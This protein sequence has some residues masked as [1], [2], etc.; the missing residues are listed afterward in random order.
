MEKRQ[1]KR[2]I[3]SLI[4][5][6]ILLLIIYGIYLKFRSVPTCFDNVKNQNEEGVDCGGV[7]Q[8][9]CAPAAQKLVVAQMGVVPSG[10]PGKY[11]F[12]V[13]I[14]NPNATFGDKN[15]YYTLNFKNVAGAVIASR[16]GSSYILPG[17][18]KYVIESNIESA[19]PPVSFDFAINSSDWVEFN[20]YYEKPDLQ[21][22]N[23]NYYEVSGGVGFSEAYGLLKNKSAYDFDL[24]RVEMILKDKDGKILAL[25]STQMKTVAADEQR[26]FKVAWPNRFPGT[27]GNMEAQVEV[28][29]FNSDT[30]M[31]KAYKTEKFQQY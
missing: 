22:V 13:Q 26:D 9:G 27:V 8:K 5:A 10:N 31:K 30:F 17:E 23:K 19:T 14:T 11:D 18:N 7:C 25:N 3:I 20:D 21:I 12:Y 16:K 2:A 1:F 15:F 4:Y 6:T 29:V 28:D 24:I